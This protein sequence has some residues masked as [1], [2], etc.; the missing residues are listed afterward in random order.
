[1][2]LWGQME[3]GPDAPRCGSESHAFLPATGAGSTIGFMAA[4]LRSR[5]TPAR[6]KSPTSEGQRKPS[7]NAARE[8]EC[9]IPTSVVA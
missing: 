4:P 2:A 8:S 9:R 7:D 3:S 1:M 5:D 6:P